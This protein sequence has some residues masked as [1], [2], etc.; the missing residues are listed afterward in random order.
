VGVLG[1]YEAL[2]P[3]GPLRDFI[4]QLADA[5]LSS[6]VLLQIFCRCCCSR[7]RSTS[8]AARCSTTSGRC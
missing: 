5:E 7:W 3:A 8:T 4:T 1:S 6:D 2:L